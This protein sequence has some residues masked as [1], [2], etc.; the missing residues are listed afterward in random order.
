MASTRVITEVATVQADGVEVFY[1]TAG[2]TDAPVVVLLHGF[3]SS[4][5]MFRNLIP[6]LATRYRVVALDLPGF[7]FTKVPAERNYK[8]TFASLAQTFTA[9]TDAL[10]LTRF[11]LYIFDYGA[12]TAFRFALDRPGAVAAIVSQN[13][14]AYVE[15]LGQPF[16]SQIEMLWA[17]GA[18]EDRDALR[19][20]LELPATQWQYQN[21]SPHPEAIPPEAF[22]LDQALMDRPGNKE[23]QLD[24]FQDYGSNVK[25][26]PQF[27]EYLRSSGVPVLTAWGKADEIFVAPG[28]EA[29]RRDVKKLETRWL[30]AGHFA[31]ETNEQQMAQWILEFFDKYD[32]FAA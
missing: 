9:F 21:G 11:A 15:G 29:Y 2:P 24:L 4:S 23:I 12:P 31:L 22:H 26:Y 1:R 32:V 19:P 7:G 8:Y 25:L 27:Q 16:W 30:D 6:L 5:H 18:Q 13:G 28:A 3:P 17:S 14:N 10:S 20:L